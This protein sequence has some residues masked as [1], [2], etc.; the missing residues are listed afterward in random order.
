MLTLIVHDQSVTWPEDFA[1]V[2]MDY[3]RSHGVPFMIQGK[4]ANANWV[5]AA[6]NI[7][8]P[9]PVGST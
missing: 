2:M 7:P 3:Y 8:L 9:K 1:Y 6:G 5:T 4:C